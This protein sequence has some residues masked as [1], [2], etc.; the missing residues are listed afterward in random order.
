MGRLARSPKQIGS[1]LRRYRRA[2]K[3]SQSEL[4]KRAG[5]RQGTISL[6]E[7]GSEGVKLS[8]VMD[9]LRALD[10]ELVIQERT[11]GSPQDIEEMF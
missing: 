11:K 8:T 9:I 4:G 5:V 6:V 1:A 7:N 10:L 3:K 2:Q